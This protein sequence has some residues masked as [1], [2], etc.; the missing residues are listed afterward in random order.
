MELIHTDSQIE[1]SQEELLEF[2]ETSWLPKRKESQLGLDIDRTLRIVNSIKSKPKAWSI[3]VFAASV[4]NAETIAG[5]LTLDGIPAAAISSNTPAHER[6]LAL[7]RFRSKE[8]RVLTNYNVLSQGFDAPKTDAVYITRPTQ[9]EVRYQQMI[10]RGLR[11]PRNGGTEEVHLVN[12]LDNIRE[13]PL[14]INY[15]PFEVLADSVDEG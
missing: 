15:K 1:L 14:S 6:A 2:K 10:G 7:D 13:F 5:M 3:I 11:G 4:E 12:V 8:L 9:S